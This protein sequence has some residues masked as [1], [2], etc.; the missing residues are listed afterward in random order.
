MKTAVARKKFPRRA[1]TLIEIMIVV[2]IIG[3]IAALGVPAILQTFRKEGMRKAV[4]EVMDMC[5][6]ARA[7]A[8]LSGRPTEVDFYP[9]E[10]RLGI[11]DAPLD[12][13]QTPP[14]GAPM[15]NSGT[16]PPTSS[17]LNTEG[18]VLLPDSVDIAMLDINL[19]DCSG[20]DKASVHFFQNGTCEELTLVLHSGDEW[21]KITLEFSTALASVGPVTR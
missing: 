3:L 5:S 20:K 6:D 15:N 12:E 18:S 7:R 14:T 11:A 4:S 8:I 2:A 21:D 17:P 1:F 9:A 16:T 19:I 13:S 10:K